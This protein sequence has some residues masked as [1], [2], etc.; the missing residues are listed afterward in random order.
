MLKGRG[1]QAQRPPPP[2]PT[3]HVAR[4]G[5]EMRHRCRVVSAYVAR[6]RTVERRGAKEQQLQSPL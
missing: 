6:H 2:R 4:K 5:R 3:D 1:R